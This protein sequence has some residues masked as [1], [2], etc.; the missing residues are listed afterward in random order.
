[1]YL[2]ARLGGG[3]ERIGIGDQRLGACIP[4]ADHVLQQIAGQARLARV[5]HQLRS[6]T[7]DAA[8]AAYQV[9]LNVAQERVGERELVDVH[10]EG[11][12][13][14]AAGQLDAAHQ[15]A[16]LVLPAPARRKH[17]L[18]QQHG[19]QQ[20]GLVVL[21]PGC[22]RQRRHRHAA[23]DAARACARHAGAAASHVRTEARPLRQV[24]PRGEL[25]AAAVPSHQ[26]VRQRLAA[27]YVHQLRAAD[28]L[29]R[30]MQRACM[31]THAPP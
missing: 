5:E 11:Q 15:A 1:M 10:G 26:L 14:G 7:R 30:G 13:G 27:A 19:V 18:Q 2:K 22:M 12:C 23:Q 25:E 4:V 28:G 21:A 24:G 17:L 9:L 8:P 6:V 29:R 3:H 31:C 16:H 20:A